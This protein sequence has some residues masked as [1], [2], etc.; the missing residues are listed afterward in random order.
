VL[1]RHRNDSLRGVC[2]LRVLGYRVW[3]IDLGPD[4]P[5]VATGLSRMPDVS[6]ELSEADFWSLVESPTEIAS[7]LVDQQRL[8]ISGSMEHAAMLLRVLQ[9]E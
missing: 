1:R 9:R 2:E 5:E 4:N 3:T 6:I 8:K 7:Q